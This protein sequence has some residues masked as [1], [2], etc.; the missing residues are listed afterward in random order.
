MAQKSVSAVFLIGDVRETGR[1]N[2]ALFPARCA[3]GGQHMNGIGRLAVHGD[4]R[5]QRCRP[6]MRGRTAVAS[7]PA[8]VRGVLDE[9]DAVDAFR[10]EHLFVRGP[11]G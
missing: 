1:Q 4:Q 5:P 3:A 2:A 7:A 8:V 6:D 11:Q 10:A 9:C